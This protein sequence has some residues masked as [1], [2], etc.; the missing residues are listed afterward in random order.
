MK[1]VITNDRKIRSW[2]DVIDE[3]ELA[4]LVVLA[5]V[6]MLSSP[7]LG[8]VPGMFHL[9]ALGALGILLLKRRGISVWLK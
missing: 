2:I 6:V 7:F 5:E 9:I 1:L 3:N 4:V 8:A